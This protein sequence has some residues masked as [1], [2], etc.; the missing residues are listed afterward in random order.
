[1]SRAWR[2]FALSAAIVAAD[3]LTKWLVLGFFE[4]RYP[5]VELTGFC[6]AI[7][8]RST[9]QSATCFTGRRRIWF[10]LPDGRPVFTLHSGVQQRLEPSWFSSRRFAFVATKPLWGQP[11]SIVETTVSMENP[12]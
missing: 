10:T 4:N 3:Q 2:W 9:V 5:R 8:H 11:R 7:P 6:P 12:L 1:M